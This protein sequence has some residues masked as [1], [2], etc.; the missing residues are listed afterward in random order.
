MEKELRCQSA[1][2]RNRFPGSL[3]KGSRDGD[4]AVF[5]GL[6]LRLA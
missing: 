3:P 2:P 5:I 6:W 4:F 1:L